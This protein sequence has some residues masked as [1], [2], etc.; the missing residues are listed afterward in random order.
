MKK[1]TG[2]KNFS[3]LE[4]KKLEKMGVIVGGIAG[5]TNDKCTTQTTTSG[6]GDVV[7]LVDGVIKTTIYY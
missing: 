3:S 5:A 6:G 2:M 1:L 7:T 4:N